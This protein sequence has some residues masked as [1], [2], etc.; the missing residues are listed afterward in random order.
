MVDNKSTDNSLPILKSL[1]SADPRFRIFQNNELVPCLGPSQ[2]R[3]LALTHVDTPL[4]AFCDIDDLWHPDKLSLQVTFHCQRSLDISV[5]AYSRVKTQGPHSCS[6]VRTILPPAKITPRMMLYRNC[7]PLSTVLIST[8]VLVDT[9][10]G[11][12]HED[13]ALWL[14]IFSAFPHIK[15]ECLPALLALYRIHLG[16]ITSSKAKMPLWAW[17]FYFYHT[18]SILISAFLAIR[19]SIFQAVRF[20]GGL[21]RLNRTTSFDLSDFSESRPQLLKQGGLSLS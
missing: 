8:A 3:N 1:V 21:L 10:P 4:V 6:I 7:I 2:A 19:W 9:F 5:T 15:C 20:V 13:Y 14:R 12:R 16:N 18:G 17:K 11:C